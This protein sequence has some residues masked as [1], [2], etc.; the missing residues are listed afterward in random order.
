SQ[1]TNITTTSFRAR[2]LKDNTIY[3]VHVRSM[4]TD[5]PSSIWQTAIFKTTSLSVSNVNGSD[6]KLEAY[7]NP[8]KNKIMVNWSGQIT[9]T[10]ILELTDIAGKVLRTI[11]MEGNR[12]ELD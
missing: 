6:N 3:Y 1:G 10:A 12:T 2:G 9:G 11:K 7:P 5:I 8:A 4:C